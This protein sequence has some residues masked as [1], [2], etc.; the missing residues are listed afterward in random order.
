[1]QIDI[2]RCKTPQ[3]V[4]KELWAHLLAYNVIRGLIAAAAE[5]YGKLPRR[6]SF[7]G[8]LQAVCAFADALRL[9]PP[10]RR[11]VLLDALL[12]TIAAHD[13]GDRPGRTEPRAVKR[14]PKPHK[15]LNEPREA[16][17]KRL[18]ARK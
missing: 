14:R 3:M 6:L 13:V 10:R 15:L 4:E 18:L 8:A 7:K 1:M 2:L 17:R 9:T 12:Q 11:P 16:A 5:A